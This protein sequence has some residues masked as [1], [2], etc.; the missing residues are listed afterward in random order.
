MNTIAKGKNGASR[1]TRATTLH[2]V[3]FDESK[4]DGARD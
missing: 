2:V 3:E 4:G 1:A